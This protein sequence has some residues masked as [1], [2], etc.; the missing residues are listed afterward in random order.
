MTTVTSTPRITTSLRELAAVRLKHAS[1]TAVAIGTFDGVHLGHQRVLAHVAETAQHNS[2]DAVIVTFDPSPKVLFL[3]QKYLTSRH[4]KLKRLAGYGFNAIVVIPFTKDYAQTDKQVFVDELAQLN[5]VH[6]IVGED[7]RFGHKREGTL[8]DLSHITGHLEVIGMQHL[9]DEPIKSSHIRRLLEAG[10]VVT[11]RKFLG[12]SYQATGT[13]TEGDKR[14]RTIGYPTAN[15]N[16]APEKALPQ[17]VF[18][19][20]VR[21]PQGVF[22][23]MANVGTRPSFETNPPSLEAHLFDFDDN[24]YG[25]DMTVSFEHYLR[26]QKAFSGLDE[27]KAQLAADAE[28]AKLSLTND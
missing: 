2:L 23:G 14:G 25:A 10:D 19:V 8:E 9:E 12:Y 26:G 28:A 22:T 20:R 17:G 1:P 18:S 5:P 3:G 24:L 13:V 15:L 7:F 6:I 16:L 21:V 4:E 27:L 11:A